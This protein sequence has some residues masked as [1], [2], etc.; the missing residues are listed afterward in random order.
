M[1][2]LSWTGSSIITPSTSAFIMSCNSS[3]L[4]VD[5]G[6]YLTLIPNDL[7]ANQE[8]LHTNAEK[9]ANPPGPPPSVLRRMVSPSLL[10][11]TKYA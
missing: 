3:P 10:P 2:Y 11:Y 6:P 4:V 8:Q 9:T 1:M 5:D 7:P